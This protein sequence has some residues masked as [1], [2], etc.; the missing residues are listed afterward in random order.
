VDDIDYSR[1]EVEA[2]LELFSQLKLN[3][4]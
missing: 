3:S 2:Q 1:L 4:K